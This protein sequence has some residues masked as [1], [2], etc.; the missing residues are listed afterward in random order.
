MTHW[1]IG[2]ELQQTPGQTAPSLFEFLNA[3]VDGYTLEETLAA[4]GPRLRIPIYLDRAALAAHRIDLAQI[5]VRLPRTRIFYKRLI[6]RVLAQARMG[7]ELRIDEAGKPFLW[8]T[9]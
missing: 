4:I 6:D 1:P 3:E 2:W 9:R 8:V 5:Q 7:S